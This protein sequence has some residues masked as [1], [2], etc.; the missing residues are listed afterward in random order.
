MTSVGRG[1][2]PV[3]FDL[4]TCPLQGTNLIEAGAGTGKTYSLSGLFLRLI[5]EKRLPVNAILVVTFTVAATEELR[6]R[7]RRKL[8]ETLAAYS[9]GTSP[10]AFIQGLIRKVP[11]RVEAAALLRAALLDF[12]EAAIFTIHGFCQRTLYESAFESSSLFDTELAPERE[13][14]LIAE[15]VQ[16]FWRRHFYEAFPEWVQL[17]P[18][19]ES[20]PGF[21]PGPFGERTGLS[22]PPDYPPDRACG[23]PVPG[24]LPA[25]LR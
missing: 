24:S 15:I 20:R 11:D 22:R 8:R 13:T 25:G 4:L 5:L 1:I 14:G 17:R 2:N 12:D 3:R 6:D 23:L 10:D 7:I 9:T 16:D 18:E 21:F 19:P